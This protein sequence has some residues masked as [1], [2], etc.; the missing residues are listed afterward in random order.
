MTG[1]SPDEI[2]LLMVNNWR[3]ILII[4]FV[5]GVLVYGVIFYFWIQN[6]VVDSNTKKNNADIP[7]ASDWE[8]YGSDLLKIDYPPDWK[9]E[10][11]P[12]VGG[13]MIMIK[14]SSLG[15]EEYLPSFSLG[16][17]KNN[18][19][20]AERQQ[21]FEQLNFQKEYINYQGTQVPKFSGA[22]NL[23]GK[24]TRE[25]VIF[26]EKTN[27]IYLIKY[28]Y[29]GEALNPELEEKFRQIFESLKIY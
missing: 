24:K 21:I 4:V 26:I 25:S 13:S 29:E 16:I 3:K 19:D 14:P 11:I 2:L 5:A 23:R 27:S 28:Q 7:V 17:S 10:S 12:V 6:A 9:V 8:T 18:G 20:L 22:V 1:L 15:K